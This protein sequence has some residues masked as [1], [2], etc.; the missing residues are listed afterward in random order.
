MERGEEVS[1]D[2]TYIENDTHE[3]RQLRIKE[4]RAMWSDFLASPEHWEKEEIDILRESAR[5]CK[6]KLISEIKK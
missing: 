4:I 3:E 2:L 6:I 1:E 5:I